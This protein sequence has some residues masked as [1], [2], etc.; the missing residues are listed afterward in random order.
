MPRCACVHVYI[1]TADVYHEVELRR[2]GET[3]FGDGDY[4]TQLHV[5]A[6]AY[7]YIGHFGNIYSELEYII[8]KN[9]YEDD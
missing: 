5:R 2:F 1:K 8:S 7:I 9:R 6:F 4:V 3:S